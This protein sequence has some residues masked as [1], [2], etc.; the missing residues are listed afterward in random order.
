[1]W[2]PFG[3]VAAMHSVMPVPVPASSGDLPPDQL[4]D[5]A[6]WGTLDACIHLEPGSTTDGIV[7]FSLAERRALRLLARAGLLPTL[8]RREAG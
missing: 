8:P 6:R 7:T 5:L 1:M 4:S 2:R 3:I